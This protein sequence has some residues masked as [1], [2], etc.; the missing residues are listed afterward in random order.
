MVF[1]TNEAVF[2][3]RFVFQANPTLLWCFHHVLL[4]PCCHLVLREPTNGFRHFINTA[5]VLTVLALPTP[6]AF[7]TF[8][9]TP[10]RS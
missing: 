7:D 6:L 5:G 1:D 4:G 3:E 8:Y 2:F 10:L 9:Q